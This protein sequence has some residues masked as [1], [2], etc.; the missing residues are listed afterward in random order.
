MNSNFCPSRES[1]AAYNLGMLSPQEAD[2]IAQHLESCRQCDTVLDSMAPV[3]DTLV[4]QLRQ[5]A[6]RFPYGSEDAF[7]N[8]LAKL[9]AL[10]FSPSPQEQVATAAKASRKST[11]SDLGNLREYQLLV[12]IGSGGMGTVYKARHQKLKR[13]VALKIL[14]QERMANAAA[15]ARFEREMEA[16]GKLDH[17]NIVRATDAGEADGKHFLVMEL[18]EGIDL[19]RLSKKYGKLPIA[20]AC[21]IVRQ[22]ALGLQHAHEHGLVHR[23]IKPS[24]LLLARNRQVKILD[25][26]LARLQSDQPA[27]DEL[28]HTGQIMGTLDYM[29]PEQARSDRDIDIRADIYA[30]GCTLYKLLS[31]HAPFS[32]GKQQTPFEKM[33]AH[34]ETPVPPIRRHRKDVPK[35]LRAVLARMLAKAPANRFATPAEV[36]QA[37]T[38]FAEGSKLSKLRPRRRSPSA[39]SSA[40]PGT[41]DS[42]TEDYVSLSKTDSNPSLPQAALKATT[43][44]KKKPRSP[45]ARGSATHRQ[46]VYGLLITGVAAVLLLAA[47]IWWG[48]I[49]VRFATGKG[50]LVIKITDPKL[51]VLIEDNGITLRDTQSDRSYLLRVGR[52]SINAGSYEIDVAELPEGLAVSTRAFTLTRGG[53][54]VLEVTFEP[55]LDSAKM[56]SQRPR[57]QSPTPPPSLPTSSA[58]APTPASTTPTP[59]A[60]VLPVAPA[61][62][63]PFAHQQR[64]RPGPAEDVLPGIVP[65]PARLP[66]VSRWQVETVRPQ[67]YLTAIAYSPDGK[68]IA[69]GTATARVRIIYDASTLDLLGVLIDDPD[70]EV[71]SLAWSPNGR[72][73]AVSIKSVRIWGADGTPGVK[74]PTSRQSQLA[75]SPDS[76]WLATAGPG[77]GEV[78]LWRPDGAAGAVFTA[79]QE[80]QTLGVAWSR[81]GQWLAVR[82]SQAVQLWSADGTPGPRIEDTSGQHGIAFSP[83][84]QW[85]ATTG[86]AGARLWRTVGTPGPVLEGFPK[87]GGGLVAWSPDSSRLAAV[88]GGNIG[89]WKA[90]GAPARPWKNLPTDVLSVAWSPDGQALAVGHHRGLSI[91]KGDGSKQMSERHRGGI[92]KIAWKPDGQALLSVS[93]DWTPRLWQTDGAAQAWRARNILSFAFSPDGKRTAV[94]EEN[95]A[96]AR[97]VDLEGTPGPLIYKGQHL[98]RVAFSPDGQRLAMKGGSDKVIRLLDLDGS[99]RTLEGHSSGVTALSWDPTGKRLASASCDKTVR[100]WQND[101]TLLTII[102]GHASEVRDVAWSP[103]GTRLASVTKDGPVRLWKPDGTPEVDL[104]AV[105]ERFPTLTWSPDGKRLVTG[106]SDGN[107]RVWEW[108]GQWKPEDLR[109]HL[110]SVNAVAYSPT[111]NYVASGARQTCALRLWDGN[112]LEPSWVA[113][114]LSSG[115]TVTFGASGHL[116][117]G[118]PGVIEEELVYLIERQ[119]GHQLDVLKP[120]EFQSLVAKAK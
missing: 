31:G 97:L 108:A 43:L 41:V 64:F 30:L 13:L 54:Q 23:D 107:V 118:D 89:L 87:N 46:K 67:S 3:A 6:R 114:L 83:D 22:T 5:P 74:L 103:D 71:H 93:D 86:N 77:P 109:G 28:T 95:Q 98:D 105:V 62:Q 39:P 92:K 52:Q 100:I 9:R 78:S 113:V 40:A 104:E 15:V 51:S 4:S 37:L 102:E 1:L 120:S 29:A 11:K 69:C 8:V 63:V 7:Q 26:G 16:V 119:P 117:Y 44:T 90:D 72:H 99:L 81:D 35:Q 45:R 38:P 116:R 21:E 55:R 59:P 106:L 18:V 53:Q 75:W 36:A 84:S 33:R 48:P 19:A 96:T 32:T 60:P 58:K 57:P 17:P 70:D 82:E 73:L 65:R 94:C 42:E 34:L 101:G 115:Q 61:K 20:D 91:H 47:G 50:Q 27:M 85:L 66:G 14:S 2:A 88:A 111:G 110:D 10:P 76:Q 49:V 80:R 56:A 24:N 12:E 68:L 79:K 112:T 25:L